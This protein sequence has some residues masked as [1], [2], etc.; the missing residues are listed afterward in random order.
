MNKISHYD[1]EH[2][3]KNNEGFSGSVPQN[4]ENGNKYKMFKVFN[5][6]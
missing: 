4:C 5:P 1:F 6:T 3:N 2:K